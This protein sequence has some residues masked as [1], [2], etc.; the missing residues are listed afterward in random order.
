MAAEL[1]ENQLA[2]LEECNL[3]FSERYTDSDLEYKK[4]YDTGIPPPPI[5]CP[6]WTHLRGRRFNGERSGGGRYSDSYR[7]RNND[8]RQDSQRR[9]PSHSR[10]ESNDATNRGE[11]R[12]SNYRERSRD[13]RQD[14][15]YSQQ[16]HHRPQHYRP[17]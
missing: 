16:N 3:E 17:Y 11:G 4:V 10:Y 5:I 2:F 8:Y 15:G 6:W 9:Q 13:Y 1:T 14:S 7:D 12:Y